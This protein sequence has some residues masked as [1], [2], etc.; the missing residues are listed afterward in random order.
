MNRAAWRSLVAS[1]WLGLALAGPA[2]AQSLARIPG[3]AVTMTA[4]AG[5]RISRGFSGLENPE[6]GSSIVVAELPPEGYAQLLATFSSPKTL[7]SRMA[8]D[9]VRVTRI[10]QVTVDTGQVPLAIGGQK[11]DGKDFTKYMTVM[12]GPAAQAKTVL[13]TFNVAPRDP[14]GRDTVEATLKSIKVGRVPTLDEKLA[15]LQFTFEPSPPFRIF[16]TMANAGVSLA[17][18]DGTDRTGLKPVIAITRASTN[19]APAETAQT[20]VRLFKNTSGFAEAEI[21]EERAAEFAGGAGYYVSGVAG[22]RALRQYIRVLPGGNYVRLIARGET[23]A[24]E[25]VSAAIDEI[26]ASVQPK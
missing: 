14:L 15:Q 12:G 7:S 19:S 9:G 25:E 1:G 21:N 2:G 5:Y 11:Q 18:F 4:P 16:D 17:S 22:E 3:T 24:L 20:A 6:T 8:A 26:A 13:V 23:A 10:E